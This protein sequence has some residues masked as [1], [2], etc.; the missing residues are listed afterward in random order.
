[1]IKKESKETLNIVK[2]FLTILPE[3]K[4]KSWSEDLIDD[5]YGVIENLNGEDRIKY[6]NYITFINNYIGDLS[7]SYSL[8]FKQNFIE[9]EDYYFIVKPLIEC[10]P[11]KDIKAVNLIAQ[12]E[13]ERRG[14]TIN[15]NISQ[16][17]TGDLKKI[18]FPNQYKK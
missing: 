4:Y 17:P 9:I 7:N 14:I 1:M 16:D 12:R 6:I 2:Y 18:L 15:G 10:V 8:M 5:Y 13:I 11:D 3:I